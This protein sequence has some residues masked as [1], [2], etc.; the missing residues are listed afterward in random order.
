M[1]RSKNP[2][3]RPSHR[4]EP[5]RARR[6]GPLTPAR[7]AVTAVAGATA[8]GG[9]AVAATLAGGPHGAP[10]SHGPTMSADGTTDA[11]V[12]R[13]WAASRSSERRTSA[14]DPSVSPSDAPS[15]GARPAGTTAP[16]L[17]VRTPAVPSLSADLTPPSATVAVS[18]PA[19]STGQAGAGHTP[20]GHASGHGS[21]HG[22]GEGSDG[23][24]S[25]GGSTPSLP[26]SPI[27]VTTDPDDLLSSIPSP[28]LATQGS[29]LL[30]TGR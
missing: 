17:A 18:S 25:G 24:G 26:G 14:A 2:Q 12:E 8:I 29:T 22:S 19:T 30:G 23:Q 7:A 10:A 3:Q 4:A 20:A 1:R 15:A 5:T 11:V 6:S 13:S 28:T 9:L 27:T 16:P 21:G